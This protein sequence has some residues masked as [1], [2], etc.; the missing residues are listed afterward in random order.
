M[1]SPNR[2]AL[3]RVARGLGPL[4]RGPDDPDRD[5][6]G[7]H[8]D[9]VGSLRRSRR[10]G[11]WYGSHV[12]EDIVVVVAG[13]PELY[14]ETRSSEPDLRAYL[15]QEAAAFLASGVAQDAIAGALPDARTVAGLVGKVR[16]R[17]QALAEVGKPQRE[18]GV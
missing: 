15:A 6:A 8:R 3:I 5:R 16:S 18:P 14:D 11:D 2:D 13:R 7:I 12:I 9:E 17:F 10:R 1:T 4:D